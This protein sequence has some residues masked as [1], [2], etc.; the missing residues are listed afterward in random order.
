MRIVVTGALGHI[1]SYLIRK[2]GVSKS[3]E[4][5]ILID[6]LLTLRFPSI[7]NLPKNGKYSFYKYDLLNND[8]EYLIKGSDVVI[9]LAAITDAESSF[10]Q[11]D[12]VEKNNYISTSK[13]ADACLKYDVRLLHFS[14]T[15]VYGTQKT[16]VDE[17]CTENDLKPQSPYAKT[18]LKEEALILDYRKKGLKGVTLRFGTIFGISEGMR[19]HTAVNKFCWQAAMK[20]PITVWETAYNQKRP[21]L[22][23]SDASRAIHHIIKNNLFEEGVYNILTCN[24][25]VR[26]IVSIIKD[27]VENLEIKFVKSKIM[28]QLSYEVSNKKFTKT[29]FSFRGNLK[30]DISSTIALLSN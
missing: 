11:P 1:G 6:N 24:Q 23:L 18:K 26:D 28:N 21:Y 20:E 2:L 13:V 15:S 4:S 9:H 12:L 27:N 10:D 22:S 30:K 7:F 14:S 29:G 5:I 8:F 25:T 17:N 19:F 3:I 16:L